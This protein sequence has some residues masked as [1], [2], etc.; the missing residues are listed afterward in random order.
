M[1]LDPLAT[2]DD[3]ETRLGRSVS[4]DF[5]RVEA[6]IE[7]ASAAVRLYTGRT[8]TSTSLTSRLHARGGL[9]RIPER[10]VTAVTTVKTLVN[11]AATINVPFWWDGLNAVHV[12]WGPNQSNWGDDTGDASGLGYRW[13]SAGGLHTARQPV[14]ELVYTAGAADVPPAVLAVVCGVVLR[15]YGRNPDEGGIQQESIQG[16][17][18]TVG[19][20]G[21]AGPVGLL[22]A[23]QAILDRYRQPAVGTIWLT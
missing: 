5:G 9:I 1:A 21:A 7:D 10:P 17:S 2:V 12:R 11:G 8:F 19:S 23:E 16:Y 3:I 6:L 18:Y 15:A 13:D 22:P 20:A 14:F 4:A